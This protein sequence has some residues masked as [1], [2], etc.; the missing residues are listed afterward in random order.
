MRVDSG[1]GWKGGS[2]S[3][4][5]KMFHFVERAHRRSS[6]FGRADIGFRCRQRW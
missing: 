1:S 2:F 5:Y 4:F 3:R 6:D